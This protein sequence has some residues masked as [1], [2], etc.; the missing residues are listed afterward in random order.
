MKENWNECLEFVIRA[1]GGLSKDPKDPGGLTDHGITQGVYDE[2]RRRLGE[3]TQSVARITLEEVS[4]IYY[5]SYWGSVGDQLPTGV[6]LSWFD[7]AVNAGLHQSN[8]TLQRAVMVKADGI[9]GPETL[10]AVKRFPANIIVTKFAT[11]RVIFY[12]DLDMPRFTR[13]WINR[14]EACE[15][16]ALKMLG[17]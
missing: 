10:A 4:E 5:T 7:F 9:I 3:P 6:D 13:G 2:A 8:V 16:E 12:R 17:E 1:E 14:T 11:L 15:A